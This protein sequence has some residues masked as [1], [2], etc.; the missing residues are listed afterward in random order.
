M[1]HSRFGGNA[2]VSATQDLQSSS[3]LG[4]GRARLR[5]GLTLIELVIV[6]VILAAL[7]GIAVQSLEPIADQSRYEASQQ[8]LENAGGAIFQ[9]VNDGSRVSYSGF[10]TDIGRLPVSIGTIPQ[11]FASELWNND[12]DANGVPDL[13]AFDLAAFDDPE[14][15]EDESV[16]VNN[17]ILVSAGWRGP[18]LTLTPGRDSL[19]D[20]FGHPIVC[21]DPTDTAIAAAGLQIARLRSFG[22][23]NVQS[24]TDTGYQID[25]DLPEG[26]IEAND[27]QGTL[28]IHV[29]DNAGNDPAVVGDRMVV[30]VYGPVAGA[31]GELGELEVDAANAFRVD[32]NG[33]LAGTRAVRV[34]DVSD[35]ATNEDI[36]DESLVN[37]VVVH[38]GQVTNLE[39]RMP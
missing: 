16:R 1:L 3:C 30:R 14:T 10:V 24:A 25:L 34:I 32:F 20:G 19:I 6:L 28:A 12:R 18:Y 26:L 38:P 7:T 33:L 5:L 9:R 17:R 15:N 11:R 21:F 31:A 8:T 37:Y 4:Q 35:T 27:Y 13:P 23:N 36:E 2:A 22:S 39:I 29:R